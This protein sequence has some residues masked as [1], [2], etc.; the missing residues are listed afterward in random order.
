VLVRN[1][2][3]DFDLEECLDINVL[4]EKLKENLG[5]ARIEVM[6]R[7]E[8]E[9]EEEITNFIDP[10]RISPTKVSKFCGLLDL[11]KEAELPRKTY[12]KPDKHFMYPIE[13]MFRLLL[14]LTP[15]ERSINRFINE[16]LDNENLRKI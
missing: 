1:V 8:D 7:S 6:I 2:D 15:A 13:A 4:L 5:N 14:V 12:K 16:R 11:S 10:S 9:N 3:K